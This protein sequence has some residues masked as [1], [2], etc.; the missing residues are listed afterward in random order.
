MRFEYVDKGRWQVFKNTVKSLKFYKI[1]EVPWLAE[2]L[3]F[4]GKYWAPVSE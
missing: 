3:L 2:E 1:Q 4:L